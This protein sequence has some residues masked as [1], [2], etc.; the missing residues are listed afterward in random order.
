MLPEG[1]NVK[2][3]C[4]TRG[5]TVPDRQRKSDVWDS[6]MTD[7]GRGGWVSDLYVNTPNIGRFSP[8]IPV[9]EGYDESVCP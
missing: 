7:D 8:P 2:I 5:E 6:I 1:T 4:Q 3:L 9:C